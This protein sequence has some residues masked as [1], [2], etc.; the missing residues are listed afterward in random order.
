[1]KAQAKYYMSLVMSV[2]TYHIRSCKGSGEPALSKRRD[3][4]ENSGQK[5]YLK[6]MFKK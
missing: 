5:L 4:D 2:C 3:I 1:M 6:R